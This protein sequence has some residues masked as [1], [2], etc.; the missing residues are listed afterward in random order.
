[1]VIGRRNGQLTTDWEVADEPFDSLH[2]DSEVLD[3]AASLKRYF[4]GDRSALNAIATGKGTAFQVAVWT[5]CRA[6]PWG[7]TRTYGWI[8]KRLRK[9]PAACRAVGQALRRNPLSV[10]VPCHRVVGASGPGGYAGQTDGPMLRVKRSLLEL[11]RA[12]S[13]LIHPRK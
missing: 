4:Q 8:A 5:A 7:E 13:D 1:M 2:A 10:I 12:P 3:C 6:I 9:S 11:E